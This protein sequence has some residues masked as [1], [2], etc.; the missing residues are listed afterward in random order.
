MLTDLEPVPAPDAALPALAQLILTRWRGLCDDGG[1]R[2]PD[3]HDLA[4]AMVPPALLPWSMTYRRDPDRALT[5]GVVGEE[6]AFLFHGNPRGKMVLDYAT[7]EVRAARYTIIHR[8]LDDGIPVWYTARL[9]FESGMADLGRLALPT[10]TDS[11]E[12]LLLI[13]LPLTPLP[14]MPQ[15]RQRLGEEA[16][17]LAWL[18]RRQP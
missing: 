11:G 2:L 12:A 10:R 4:P 17:Q 15:R 18:S 6:L 14:D 1:R 13:Y 16:H 3:L 8:S 5:Y 9:L 7:P